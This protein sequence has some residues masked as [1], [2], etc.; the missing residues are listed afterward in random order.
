[1]T[2]LIRPALPEDAA[3]IARIHVAAWKTAYAGI[4]DAAYLAALSTA[5]RESYW[6]K[7]IAQGGPDGPEVLLAQHDSTGAVLG[8]IA[9]GD[10]R[11]HGAPAT[12]GEVWAI[13]ADPAHWSLGV[14]HRLWLQA[15]QRLLAR[16]KTD[17]SL[18]V[19]AA[20]APGIRFYGRQG[21]APEAGGAKTVTVAGSALD[22]LRY[23]C[24]LASA[25]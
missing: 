5:Q 2:F 23:V 16:G 22:E 18:W 4:I 10:C 21:F 7:A 12:R 3:D 25:T 6:A 11:D 1:M 24:S 8:W 9:F 20:N 19:L 15:R 17:A 13:Y 14:G